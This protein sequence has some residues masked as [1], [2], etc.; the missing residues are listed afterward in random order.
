MRFYL[1]PR[2]K[3]SLTF[4]QFAKLRM[5][6]RDILSSKAHDARARFRLY[7]RTWFGSDDRV[8]EL[9]KLED[10][11]SVMREDFYA[12]GTRDT[13]LDLVHALTLPNRPKGKGSPRHLLRPCPSGPLDGPYCRA[14]QEYRE[15]MCSHKRKWVKI[16]RSSKNLFGDRVQKLGEDELEAQIDAFLQIVPQSRQKPR[17]AG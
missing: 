5:G 8:I 4:L 6:F 14:H 1:K 2:T 3:Q 7:L 9:A 16:I 17:N 13:L 15:V 10:I 12:Y 11:V